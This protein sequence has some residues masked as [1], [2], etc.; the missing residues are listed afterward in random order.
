MEIIAHKDEVS[1]GVDKGKQKSLPL[2]RSAPS[3]LSAVQTHLQTIS[4]V[5]DGF[6]PKPRSPIPC[7]RGYP[8]LENTTFY[9]RSGLAYF[10]NSF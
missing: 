7:I 2:P 10:T 9:L 1:L 8:W 3:V 6:T 5:K 4:I